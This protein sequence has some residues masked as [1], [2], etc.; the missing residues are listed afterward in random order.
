MREEWIGERTW[1]E[2]WEDVLTYMIDA[3]KGETKSISGDVQKSQF[4]KFPTLR[5]SVQ[6]KADRLYPPLSLCTSY[7]LCLSCSLLSPY[8]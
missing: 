4:T 2:R 3:I 6:I 1:R 5:F 7:L 8:A